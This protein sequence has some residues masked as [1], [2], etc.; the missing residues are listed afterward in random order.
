MGYPWMQSLTGVLTLE[1]PLIWVTHCHSPLRV[2]LSLLWVAH[3]CSPSGVSLPLC[4]SPTTAVP[5][6]YPLHHGVPPSKD[7][8]PATSPAVSPQQPL[9]LRVSSRMSPKASPHLFPALY[10]CSFF[11]NMSDLRCGMLPWKTEVL[12]PYRLLTSVSELTGPSCDG[13][14]AREKLIPCVAV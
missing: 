5:R 9:P 10:S 2:F 1:C 13:H 12:V 4:G 14:S 3:S 6:R 11:I 7:A 8:S